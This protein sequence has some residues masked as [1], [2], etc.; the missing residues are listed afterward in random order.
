MIRIYLKLTSPSPNPWKQLR[1]T[2]VDLHNESWGKRVSRV[3]RS[4][5]VKA[6][7]LSPLMVFEV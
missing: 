1:D 3:I 4:V 7:V 2:A 5:F 6:L